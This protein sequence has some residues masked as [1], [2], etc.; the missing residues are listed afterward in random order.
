MLKG[1]RRFSQKTIRIQ[2]LDAI[3]HCFEKG[4]QFGVVE[5]QVRWGQNSLR[6]KSHKDGATSLLHLGITLGGHRI[7]RLGTFPAS[8]S[9]LQQPP[10]FQECRA[11]TVWNA[12]SA[13]W[14]SE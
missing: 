8:D 4:W 14:R 3:M 11:E 7:L 12:N 10:G 2:V 6:T 13:G 9:T 5:A 1:L